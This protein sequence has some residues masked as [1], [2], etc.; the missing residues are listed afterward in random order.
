MIMKINKAAAPKPTDIIRAFLCQEAFQDLRMRQG[1]SDFLAER[2]AVKLAEARKAK[3]F[4]INKLAWMS[5]VSPKA[6][7]FIE[8]GVHSP[9]LKT[10]FRLAVALELD[11]P[12]AFEQIKAAWDDPS[13]S[14]EEEADGNP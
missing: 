10:F 13:E 7:A 11:L 4:S 1:V 8:Q 2:L 9:T 14:M 12:V 3:G 6:I 5:G